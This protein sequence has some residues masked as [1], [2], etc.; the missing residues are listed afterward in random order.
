MN[1]RR[2]RSR[3]SR[4]RDRTLFAGDICNTNVYDPADAASIDGVPRDVRGAGR[5]AAEAA[6]T[7]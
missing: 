5:W 7:T 1:R 3:K 4:R 6:S 2:S